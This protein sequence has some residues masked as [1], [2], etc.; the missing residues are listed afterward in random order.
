VAAVEGQALEMVKIHI[1]IK[2]NR[3]AI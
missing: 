3:Y 1:Q 2:T